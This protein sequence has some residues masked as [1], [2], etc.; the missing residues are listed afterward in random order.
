MKKI[1]IKIYGFDDS[2]NSLIFSC[3]ST[4]TD[5]SNPDD[6]PRM[7]FNNYGSAKSFDEIVNMLEGVATGHVQMIEHQESV[8]KNKI[9]KTICANMANLEHTFEVPEFNMETDLTRVEREED[10]LL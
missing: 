6:Y 3:A 5:S 9:L 2:S 8:A 4:K 10:E 7:A 1:F